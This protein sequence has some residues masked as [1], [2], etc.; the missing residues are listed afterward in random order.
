MTYNLQL[1]NGMWFYIEIL[2]EGRQITWFCLTPVPN[3]TITHV[4]LPAPMGSATPVA[5]FQRGVVEGSL[6]LGTFS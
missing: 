5:L 6:V 1:M 3:L 4:I 2:E